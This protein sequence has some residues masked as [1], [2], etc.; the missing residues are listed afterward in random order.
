MGFFKKLFGGSKDASENNPEETRQLRVNSTI[1]DLTLPL[2]TFFNKDELK[3]RV[4][5]RCQKVDIEIVGESFYKANVLGVA[6][7]AQ[8]ADFKI[9][10]LPEPT[11]KYDKQAV[12]VR[13]GG[14]HVGYIKSPFNKHWFK[15]VN[16]AA[17]EG[18]FLWGN[19]E[20]ISKRGSNNIGIFGYI[21]MSRQTPEWG[22]LEPKKMTDAALAKIADKINNLIDSGDDQTIGQVRALSKRAVKAV[23]PLVCHAKWVIQNSE[24][25]GSENWDEILN[26]CEGL[27]DNAD[28]AVYATNPEDVDVMDNLNEL[29]ELFENM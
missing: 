20:A 21:Y 7:A 26:H 1:V 3:P 24:G 11:N 23:T 19:A 8:G 15:W 14:V 18:E 16:K 12:S 22:G 17:N 10:L 25:Q 9:F 29:A 28:E 2:E 5:D 6:K 4:A 13:A 27:F